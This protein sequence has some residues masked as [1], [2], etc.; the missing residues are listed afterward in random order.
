FTENDTNTE[1]LFNVPNP[2]PYVKDG[3]DACV[4]HGKA[5]A[6]N[7]GKTGTKAAAHC[8]ITIPAGGAP[9]G[10]PRL[11]P[12]QLP[13][14]RDAFGPKFDPTLDPRRHEADE[15]YAAVLP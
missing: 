1:R 2:S 14:A 8:E 5:S 9:G 15:F 4:V 10:N 13:P 11:S 12:R 3:I 7:P 6:V